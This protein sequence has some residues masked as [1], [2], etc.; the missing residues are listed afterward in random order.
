MIIKTN[1]TQGHI[2]R[3]VHLFTITIFIVFTLIL[4][5]NQANALVPVVGSIILKGTGKVLTKTST[6]QVIKSGGKVLTKTFGK[7]GAK[8]LAK[9]PVSDTVRL[10]EYAKMAKNPEIRKTLLQYYEKGGTKFLDRLSWDKIVAGGLSISMITAAY[11]VSDGIQEGM[12]V[13]SNDSP[14]VFGKTV[15]SVIKWLIAPII[16]ATGLFFGGRTLIGLFFYYKKKYRN[17]K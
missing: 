4:S 13:V 5:T 3:F 7:K 15:S 10:V 6:K 17:H 2:T 11:K 9:A 1:K 8:I 14:E 16:L 12:K